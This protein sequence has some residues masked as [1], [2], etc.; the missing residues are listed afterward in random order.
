[1]VGGKIKVLVTGGA[2]FIGRWVVNKLLENH[3]VTALDNLS[4]GD[5][6]NISA[7]QGN[8][9]FQFI[10][11]DILN[12]EV[13]PD[14][15]KDVT[16]CIHLAAQV[17]VQD[18]LDNPGLS[19]SNNVVGTYNVLEAC[20]KNDVKI[21]IMGTC[22]VYDV[23]LSKAI[24]EN[25]PIK[26]ASPYSGSKIAAENLAFSY[27]YGYGL[28]VVILRPFNTYG[29]YQKSCAEGG[30]ISIFIENYL[31]ARDL[32]IY[33]DG[34]QTRDFLY[35]ED[36]ADFVVKAAFCKEAIGEVINAGT[37]K[38]ITINNLA[39]LIC[40]DATRI[41]HVPHI[42]PQSEIRRLVCDCSK[43][44]KLLGWKPLTTLEEG[45]KKTE[46]WISMNLSS[47]QE[48]LH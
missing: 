26:P 7:F 20:R 27:Y 46:Q 29:P 23:A 13:L 37:C 48:Y 21:V 36:C 15:F 38:D 18:S 28:P 31:R 19:F 3:D 24:N 17:N 11:A 43:A 8:K 47:N 16:V 2:G 12:S 33:G 32:L 35:V 30:V 9:R 22:M 5:M 44:K 10:S 14:A 39:S 6:R 1:M 41:K 4:N 25:H 40:K 34:N 42:H 45:I